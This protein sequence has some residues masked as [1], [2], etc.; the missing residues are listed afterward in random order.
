MSAQFSGEPH[1]ARFCAQTSCQEGFYLL[2]TG[3]HVVWVMHLND[4]QPPSQPG[5]CRE[6][7]QSLCGSLISKISWLNGQ[8]TNLL[9]TQSR[10]PPSYFPFLLPIEFAAFI[11]NAPGVG[12]LPSAKSNQPS[13]ATKLLIFTASPVLIALLHQ[14]D[15]RKGKMEHSQ[16]KIPR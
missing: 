15:W 13:L 11:N 1:L 2:L 12:F 8:S 7:T 9:L 14:L 6:L 3:L 10:T 4:T 5:M 16:A